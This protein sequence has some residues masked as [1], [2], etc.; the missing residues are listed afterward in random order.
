LSYLLAQ[1]LDGNRVSR[2]LD[3]ITR[4]Q[5]DEALEEAF[6]RYLL[7]YAAFALLELRIRGEVPAWEGILLMKERGQEGISKVKDQAN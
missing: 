5:S 4:K 2:L 1:M 7:G 6:R 3:P